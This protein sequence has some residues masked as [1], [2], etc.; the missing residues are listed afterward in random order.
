MALDAARALGLRHGPV[1]LR[2][3]AAETARYALAIGAAASAPRLAGNAPPAA[4]PTWAATLARSAR[5][6]FRALGLDPAR[7][8]QVSQGLELPGP[9][10][11]SGEASG[12]S[13]VTAVHDGGPQGAIM[14][15]RMCLRSPSGA[16]LATTW[17]R[18]LGRG[19]GGFGGRPPPALARRESPARPPDAVVEL[20]TRPDQ[21]ELYSVLGDTNPIHLDAAAARD[22]GFARPI[23]HGLCTFGIVGLAVVQALCNGDPGRLA[24]LE[25]EFLSPVYPGDTLQLAAWRAGSSRQLA[26]TVLDRGAVMAGRG[27]CRVRGTGGSRSAK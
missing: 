16:L 24:A 27:R 15:I 12:E 6:D 3:S 2:W 17:A 25:L 14:D 4:F 5:P 20:P 8:I 10:P 18:Y 22:A 23:L 13:E 7:V 26:L 19:S 11:A 1:V 21:A 9:F